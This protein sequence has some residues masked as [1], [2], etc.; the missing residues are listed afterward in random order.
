MVWRLEK[1]LK[2]KS[3]HKI[4]EFL[5]AYHF[6]E[7]HSTLVRAPS[8]RAYEAIKTVTPPEVPIF[9]V[10]MTIR[11]L[12]LRFFRLARGAQMSESMLSLFLRAGFVL[13]AE[14]V[15]R[16]VVLGVAGRFWRPVQ[17]MPPLAPTTPEEFLAFSAPDHV[18]VA[19]NFL[20]ER[21]G[22][23]CRVTT[24]TRIFAVD[25]SA[26]RKFALYWRLIYPGSALIRRN[27]LR[28]IRRRAEAISA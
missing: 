28:G 10:L 20:V 9:S 7:T 26:C 8:S 25:V 14:E 2:V 13:L 21:D 17:S 15:G 23:D 18:K 12:S 16:E 19:A 24:E 1:R 11:S 5:P 27:W 3:S 4:D 22:Q 6:H